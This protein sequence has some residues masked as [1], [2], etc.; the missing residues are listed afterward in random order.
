MGKK[1]LISN[2]LPARRPILAID[3]EVVLHSDTTA[4]MGWMGARLLPDPPVPGA[5]EWLDSLVENGDSI[6][7]FS[8]R[9][10]YWGARAAMK[11]WLVKW[12]FPEHKLGKIRFSP[13]KPPAHLLID[14]RAMQFQGSFFSVAQML[15]FSHG[16]G[17]DR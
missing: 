1:N 15:E 2:D 13:L 11:R 7:I 3:F 6:C 9:A 4:W 17:G 5:I 14:V 12:G 16:N 8:T 10:R